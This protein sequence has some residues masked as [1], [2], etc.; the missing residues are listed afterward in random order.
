MGVCRLNI[1]YHVATFRDSN[2]FVMQ[3]VHVQEKFNSD[4]L[5]PR[6]RGRGSAGKIF[7]IMLLHNVFPFNLICNMTII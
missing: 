7:A 3:H 1:C 5:S 6:I 2:K 4:L